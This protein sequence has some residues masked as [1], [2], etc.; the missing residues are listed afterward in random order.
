MPEF[1]I[2]L[3]ELDVGPTN[4]S[5]VVKNRENNWTFLPYELW[6]IVL[7]DY[8]LTSKDFAKLD[9]C[10]KWFSNPWQGKEICNSR[11]VLGMRTATL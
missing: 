10:C 6:L 9:R 1:G 7:V 11:P 5:R 2:D 4:E 8:G 3:E